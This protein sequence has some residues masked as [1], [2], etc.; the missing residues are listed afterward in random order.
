MPLLTDKDQ[1][2]T[3]LRRDPALV[4][5]RARRSVA[6]DVSESASGSRRI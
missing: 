6:A 1:I 5:L 3:I 4:R 2:R